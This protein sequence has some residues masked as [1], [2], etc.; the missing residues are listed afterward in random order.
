MCE[1]TNAES[2]TNY[3][4]LEV[5]LKTMVKRNIPHTNMGGRHEINSTAFNSLA[6]TILYT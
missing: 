5:T 4:K 1:A 6:A 3:E 2:H